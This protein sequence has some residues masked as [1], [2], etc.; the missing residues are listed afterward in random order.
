MAKLSLYYPVS[1]PNINQGF[2]VNGAYYRAN[3]INI[4]GHNGIDFQAYHG[5]PVYAAHDGTAYYETDN[6]SGHGIVIVSD[7]AYDFNNQQAHFKSIYWHFCDPEKEPKY[8]SPFYAHGANSGIGMP[9]KAGTQIGWADTTGLSSG[10][11]VHFGLKPIVAGP[12]AKSGDAPDVGIGNWVNVVPNNGYLGAV[13]PTPYFNK[14]FAQD[15]PMVIQNLQTQVTLYQKVVALI[16][17]YF[18]KK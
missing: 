14:F 11:H 1:P 5:Q 17:Q 10:D 7:D 9:V 8:D 4:D 15:A 2:G 18:Q 3:G 16:T 12:G 13:D 6:D